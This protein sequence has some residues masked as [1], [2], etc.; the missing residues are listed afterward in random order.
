MKL[1][2]RLFAMGLGV[3]CAAGALADDEDDR[4]LLKAFHEFGITRCDS[5]ILQNSRL[6]G[7]W[8]FYMSTHENNVDGPSKEASIIRILGEQGDT[9]KIDDTFIQSPK[10]CYL[11]SR[12]TLILAGSC[13]SNIDS[14][15]WRVSNSMPDKDYTAYVNRGGVEMHAKEINL[16]GARACLQEAAI[17]KNGEQG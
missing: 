14:A 13:A 4:R 11:V 7:N 15:H 5:F 9:I 17:R 6:T 8:Y 10:K 16:G 12:H 1:R 2:V 3:C